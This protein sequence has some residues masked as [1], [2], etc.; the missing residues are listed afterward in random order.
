M[1]LRTVAVV[2][3]A[4][5]LEYSPHALPSGHDERSLNARAIERILAQPPAPLTFAVVG[6][7]QQWFDEAAAAVASINA[8]GDVR[9]VV[10]IGDF[11]HVGL[12]P[13]YRLMNEIFARLRV[14]YLVVIGNHDHFSNGEA[15][16][17]EMYGPTDFAFTVGR[18]RL[19]F[20]CSNSVS[21]AFDGTVPDVAGVAGMLAPSP[22]PDR[23]LVFAHIAPSGGSM[24]DKA[25]RPRLEAALADARVALSL[26]GHTHRFEDFERGGV[27]YVVA[28]AVEY[29][30]YLVVSERPGGSTSTSSSA[31][32]RRRS[33]GRTSSRRP[34][35]SRGPR[36]RSPPDAGGRS[37]SRP[38]CS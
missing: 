36:G 6:D 14:P 18:V 8:R 29:R 13:E 7:T 5:C 20:H 28:D 4:G 17:R 22:E 26:H 3:L 16:Y 38:R 11:T 35:S 21:H 24:F 1:R 15:I 37:P 34:G 9:F 32:S 25:L 23:A 33:A 27:R 12:L 30:S 19:V 2:V 31:G 10:Q